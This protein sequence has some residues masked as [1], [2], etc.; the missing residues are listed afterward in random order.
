MKLASYAMRRVR[1]TISV[2]QVFSGSTIKDVI[3]AIAG[4]DVIASLAIKKIV[5][6]VN[7]CELLLGVVSHHV[8]IAGAAVEHIFATPTI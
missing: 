6:M 4:H 1:G 3:A 8:V 7:P 2:D 5:T